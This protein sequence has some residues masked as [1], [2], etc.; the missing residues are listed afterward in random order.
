MAWDAC[1][2]QEQAPVP[3]TARTSAGPAQYFTWQTGQKNVRRRV[4]PG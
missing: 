4:R 3:F 2:L 1:I